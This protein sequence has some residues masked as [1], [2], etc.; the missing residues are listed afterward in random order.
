MVIDILG[1]ILKLRE[2]L[3]KL[4]THNCKIFAKV[5]DIHFLPTSR[6]ERDNS[7]SIYISTIKFFK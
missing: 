5:E 6:D 4:L 1:L 7:K 2:M 3:T